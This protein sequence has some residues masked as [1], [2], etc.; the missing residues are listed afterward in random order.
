V[1]KCG[2]PRSSN[3][4][5][6]PVLH[7]TMD[8]EGHSEHH[9]L[10][11]AHS[12]RLTWCY[13]AAAKTSAWTLCLVTLHQDSV[14]PQCDANQAQLHEVIFSLLNR[15]ILGPHLCIRRHSIRLHMQQQQQSTQMSEL[16]SPAAACSTRS[17]DHWRAL[18]HCTAP[19]PYVH[20]CTA[21][22]CEP[23]CEGPACH[24]VAG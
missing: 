23:R 14:M 7:G 3:H 18:A 6:N 12:S 9:W 20:C 17:H 13:F 4:I 16:Q 1:Q 10:R 19:L 22:P 11:T 2:G 21:L 5:P 24:S 15:C 8:S